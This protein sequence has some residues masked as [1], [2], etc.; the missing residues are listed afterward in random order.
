MT[1][2]DSLA[3][4]LGASGRTLRRAAKR[5]LI[6]VHRPSPYRV[7]ISGEQRRYI[8]THWSLLR[9]LSASLRTEHNVR[10]AVLYGSAARGDDRPGSDVDLI[11]ALAD[12]GRGLPLARLALK[13]EALLERP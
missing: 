1:G 11:V 12:R 13:L 5:G 3:S 9:A 2:L 4:D 10:L 6:R 8:R 7:D